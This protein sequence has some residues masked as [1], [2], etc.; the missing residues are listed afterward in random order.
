MLEAVRFHVNETTIFFSPYYL[1]YNWDV[2]LP[3]DNIVRPRRTYYGNKHHKIFLQEM[4]ST[5]IKFGTNI[6]K[7]RRKVMN[8][9]LA[10]TKDMQFKVGNFVYKKINI[11]EGNRTYI[12]GHIMWMSKRLS[13]SLIESEAS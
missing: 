3:L 1:L 6:K 12:S 7:A 13:L 4:Y 10:K 11:G 2:I 5:F 9:S 8:E